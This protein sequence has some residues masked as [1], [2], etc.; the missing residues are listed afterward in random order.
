MPSSIK[1][2]LVH[3]VFW[4]AVEKYS[5]LAVS[6]IVSMI[7]ARLLTPK[8]Y[9]VVA[10]ATVL[11]AFLSIF[12]TMGIG[13]AVIQR[14]DFTPKD[15]NSVFTFSVCVGG[16]LSIIFFCCSWLIA[17]LYNNDLLVPIC[18]ILSIQLLFASANM[19][20][21]A[22]MAQSKKFK[23]I[24]QRTLTL[25]LL[26]GTLAVVAAYNGAGVYALLIAPVISAIGIFIWNRHYFRVK[27][28]FHASIKPIKSIFSY[29]SYLFL[30]D[31]INYFSR[32]LD[33]LIIGKT[34]SFQSLGAYEIAYKLMM[35]PMQNITS[36]IGPVMQPVLSD[37]GT[38]NVELSRKFAKI[39]KFMAAISMP[40]G[41][42]C[43]GLSADIIHFFY[44]AKWDAAIPVFGILALSIPFQGVLSITGPIYLVSNN[45]KRQFWFSM[46]NTVTTVLG[47]LIAA[48]VF[49]TIE[50]MAW[51]W[52]ITLYINFAVT[53]WLI[54]RYVLKTSLKNVLAILA[55]PTLCAIV[56]A[57]AIY[58]CNLIR[59]SDTVFI[60]LLIKGLISVLLSVILIHVSGQY[61]VIHFFANKLRK[62]KQI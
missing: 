60:S 32:N 23:Q 24:A 9:G 54:Y 58:Y 1:H 2:D 43:W 55:R 22:L 6:I 12:C 42:I 29:S 44:G 53:Y 30:Y 33:K 45:T 5:S 3:G 7:L 39:I 40:I 61:D 27:L 16:I 36:V 37:L 34:M 51:A 21:N 28:D 10:I 15:L 13:P 31:T 47:F 50:S 26:S 19:V 56:L 41:I 46:R 18:Q 59:F 48:F 17:R 52:T 49:R 4:S 38:D 20:P 25:Q 14:K 57:V 11:I 62:R 8:E 35:M